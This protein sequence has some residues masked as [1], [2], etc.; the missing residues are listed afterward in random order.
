VNE[1]RLFRPAENSNFVKQ[2]S[3]DKL[4]CNT[5]STLCCCWTTPHRQCPL[6]SRNNLQVQRRVSQNKPELRRKITRLQRKQGECGLRI[7]F[8]VVHKLKNR[9]S[10]IFF[11]DL[12]P[13]KLCNS[14][15]IHSWGDKL[16][17]CLFFLRSFECTR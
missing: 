11:A 13:I 14:L 9:K 16:R 7:Q 6:L 1:N 5:H 12:S 10:I 15:N 4:K 3:N 8:L 2:G 17:R